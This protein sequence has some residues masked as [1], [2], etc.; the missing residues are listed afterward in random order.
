[1]ERRRR[2]AGT[3]FKKGVSQADVARRLGISRVA[4]HYWH[5]VWKKGKERADALASKG[6]PG[7]KPRLTPDDTA[8][9]EQ[10]L[11]RGPLAFGY[12]T[13]VWTLER[14]TAAIK[15]TTGATYHPGHVWYIL[16]NL[17]WSCQKPETLAKERDERSIR[18]WA[19]TGWTRVQKRG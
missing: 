6:K 12:G 1:L 19:K 8:D 2:K 14:I 7:P 15:K 11:R 18:R 3:L 5:Q 13:E 10:V 9:I 4:V 17:D 16:K